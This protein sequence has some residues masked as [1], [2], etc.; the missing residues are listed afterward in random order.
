MPYLTMA[1]LNTHPMSE[2]YNIKLIEYD[3]GVVE[4]R[5]YSK[6]VNADM[7]DKTDLADDILLIENMIGTEHCNL[8]FMSERNEDAREMERLAD[9]TP[10]PVSDGDEKTYN[11]FTGKYEKLTDIQ[12]ATFM[13]ER[14]VRS[15]L[16]RTVQAVYRYSRQC[17]W[18]YFITLTFSPEVVDRH[19]FSACMKKASKWFNH[20]KDRYAKELKYLIVPEMHKDGAWHIHGVVADTDR[21]SITDSGHVTKEGQ[22]VYN[23]VGWKFGFSTATAVTDTYR[24]STYITKYI[25]KD[26]CELSKGRKRYY[27]SRNIPEPKETEFLVPHGDREEFLQSIADSLGVELEYTKSLDCEYMSVDYRFYRMQKE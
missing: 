11:P 16:N 2:A 17:E 1:T 5:T 3:N 26:L 19:D 22:T 15:S 4:V 9:G 10:V 27:R 25:T 8:R 24:V 7:V 6:I 20:Q 23:L 12:T 14:S 13:H 21:M 18:E